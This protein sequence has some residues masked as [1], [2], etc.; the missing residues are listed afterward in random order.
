MTAPQPKLQALDALKQASVAQLLFRAARLWN[1]QALLRLQQ[2]YPTARLAH[3]SVFPHVDWSGTR[4]TELASRMGVTK[5][6]ASQLVQD[7][8]GLGLLELHP[9]PDDGRAK[10]VHFSSL[11]VEALNEGLQILN[12]MQME[13]SV[14]LGCAEMA[15]LLA[16]LQQLLP[17][18]EQQPDQR[19]DT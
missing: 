12:Q 16:L 6:A 2:R 11:G 5:Q 4:I 3:T 9:D 15:Q 10:R 18:L 13:F 1:E 17:V 14:E 19:F 7:M 8:V